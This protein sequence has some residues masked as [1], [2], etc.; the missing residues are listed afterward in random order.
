MRKNPSV[1]AARRHLP[2]GGRGFHR[3]D[4]DIDGFSDFRRQFL[5]RNA[6]GQLHQ[7]GVALFLQF[8]RDL[9][10]QRVG[11]GALDRLEAERADAVELRPL[12]PEV[13]GVVG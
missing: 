12:P 4:Q 2:R 8:L 7:A 1:S 13:T 3:V 5:G 11:G 9:V 6:R 10:G